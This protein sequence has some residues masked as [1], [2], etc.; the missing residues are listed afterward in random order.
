V[1][2]GTPSPCSVL[3]SC[4]QG[5]VPLQGPHSTAGYTA[6]CR[7]SCHPHGC[8]ESITPSCLPISEKCCFFLSPTGVQRGII[9]SH[10]PAVQR[11]HHFFPSPH[12]QMR[13]APWK[14]SQLSWN[15]LLCGCLTQ[16][17]AHLD[18]EQ[19]S[20]HHGFPTSF[21]PLSWAPPKTP[22]TSPL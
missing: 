18:A 16:L 6:G 10:L 1:R 20:H 11:E 15:S 17:D 3:G 9:P 14:V 22:R 4:F 5:T 8:R 13:G 2:T 12:S 7:E 21:P 19:I